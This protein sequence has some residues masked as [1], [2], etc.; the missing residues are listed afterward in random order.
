MMPPAFTDLL[1]ILLQLTEPEFFQQM[2]LS[3]HLRNPATNVIDM[4]A[5]I[6]A[7]ESVVSSH[8][9]DHPYISIETGELDGSDLKPWYRDYIARSA[10]WTFNKRKHN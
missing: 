3:L 9:E 7:I 2:N 10:I 8:E 1:M 4:P 5:L 6:T